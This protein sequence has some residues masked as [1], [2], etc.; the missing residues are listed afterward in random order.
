MN[1]LVRRQRGIF[2]EQYKAFYC[3]HNDPSHIQ[4]IKL[5]ILPQVANIENMNDIIA[6]LAEYGTI[7]KLLI[8]NY[9]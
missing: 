8:I 9:H 5:D 7:I 1:A 2:D 3:R 6:E 4:Y